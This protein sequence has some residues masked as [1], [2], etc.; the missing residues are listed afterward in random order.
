MPEL[1]LPLAKLRFGW[2]SLARWS[3]TL[4]GHLR[5][6]RPSDHFA[7][8]NRLV[9]ARLLISRA[10][11]LRHQQLA[12]DDRVGTAKDLARPG[13]KEQTEVGAPFSI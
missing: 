1:L 12:R 2:T 13:Q 9:K 4:M 6:S 3:L 8:F 10:N 7:R 11:C 5:A